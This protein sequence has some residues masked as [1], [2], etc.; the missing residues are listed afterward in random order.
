[1]DAI[2]F[3]AISFSFPLP[4]SSIGYP[5]LVQ[6]L[7]WHWSKGKFKEDAIFDSIGALSPA[8]RNVHPI[9]ANLDS[10]IAQQITKPRQGSSPVLPRPKASPIATPGQR[11]QGWRATRSLQIS[12]QNRA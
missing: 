3:A 12:Q 1:M 11:L 8:G 4:K 9:G 10:P 7:H 2:L 5:A 6:Q